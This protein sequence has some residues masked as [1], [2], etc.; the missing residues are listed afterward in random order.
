MA[1]QS[2]ITAAERQ[3]GVLLGKLEVLTEI[4]DEA[5]DGGVPAAI[6]RAQSDITATEAMVASVRRKIEKLRKGMTAGLRSAC[7]AANAT[8]LATITNGAPEIVKASAKVEKTLAAFLLAVHDAHQVAAP[9]GEAASRIVKQSNPRTRPENYALAH[10]LGLRSGVLGAAIESAFE[11]AGLFTRIA[12]ASWLSVR[13]HGTPDVEAAVAL[14]MD[15][16]TAAMAKVTADVNK[17]I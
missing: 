8:D 6:E 5:A 3:L 16:L 11:R 17:A 4:F 1:D 13:Q 7:L 2:A 10:G 15:K 9:I 12:P 14:H